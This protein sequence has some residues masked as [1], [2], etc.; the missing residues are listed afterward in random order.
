MSV[1]ASGPFLC[2]RSSAVA[3]WFIIWSRTGIA[4]RREGPLTAKDA[5]ER[6]RELMALRCPGVRIKDER[7]KDVSFVQLKEATLKNPK[8]NTLPK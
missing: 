4:A 3:N 5:L 7:G 8:S 6:V 1:L 2:K